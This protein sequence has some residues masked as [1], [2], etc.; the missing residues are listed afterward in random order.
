MKKILIYSFI[1]ALF[2]ITACTTDKA[3]KEHSDSLE[4]AAAAD[5]MLKE[6]LAADTLNRDTIKAVDTLKA[7]SL[8]Q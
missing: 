1:A 8:K 5:S 7:D 3:G 2:S 6:V 4:S